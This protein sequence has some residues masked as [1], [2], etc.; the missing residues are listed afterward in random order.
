MGVLHAERRREKRL[1]DGAPMAAA[2]NRKFGHDPSDAVAGR[3]RSGQFVA[4]CGP[5]QDAAAGLGD[6]G[7]A[8]RREGTLTAAQDRAAAAGDAFEATSAAGEREVA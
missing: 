5:E 1:T 7:A 4:Q 2:L 8:D 6:A 3:Q